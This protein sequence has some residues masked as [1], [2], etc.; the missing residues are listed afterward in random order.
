MIDLIL[1]G[2]TVSNFQTV[3]EPSVNE[4]RGES[5]TG[6]AVRC[7]TGVLP[8]GRH[9]ALIIQIS[10]GAYLPDD[11]PMEER[12]PFTAA[13]GT[14]IFTFESS[15]DCDRTA[16]DNALRTSGLQIAVP[17]LRGV[18]VGTCELLNLPSVFAFPNFGPDDVTWGINDD[19]E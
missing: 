11:K 6:F 7:D 3:L 8:D 9:G 13:E 14:F 1:I 12:E 4:F 10:L 16:M 17:V 15:G 5:Q 2:H 18:L 19:D